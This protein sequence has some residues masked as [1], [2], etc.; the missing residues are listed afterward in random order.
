MDRVTISRVAES[1]IPRQR[2]KRVRGNLSEKFLQPLPGPSLFPIAASASAV[3]PPPLHSSK[4]NGRHQF[5]RKYSASLSLSLS[6]SLP[7]LA[8]ARID[9]MKVRDSAAAAAARKEAA[10]GK[11]M[12]GPSVRP[13]PSSASVP[14]IC[15]L[16]S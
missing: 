1:D 5:D 6:P 7:F 3:P 15:S 4:I 14:P 11:R 16:L 8:M 9:V 12:E 10:M 13:S 2:R